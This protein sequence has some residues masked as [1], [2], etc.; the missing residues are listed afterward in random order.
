MYCIGESGGEIVALL[1]DTIE[2]VCRLR[3]ALELFL[4]LGEVEE[5]G[6]VTEGEIAIR[7]RRPRHRDNRYNHNGT[8]VNTRAQA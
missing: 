7:L 6:G 5:V 1:L 3:G 4:G 2:A 8:G